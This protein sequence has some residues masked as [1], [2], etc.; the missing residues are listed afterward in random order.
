MPLSFEELAGLS[1]VVRHEVLTGELIRRLRS[2]PEVKEEDVEA[3]VNQL[4]TQTLETVCNGLQNSGV[5]LEQIRTA[6]E[7]LGLATPPAEVETSEEYNPTVLA[8]M[9]SSTLLDPSTLA[10]TAS[11]PEHP[12]TPVS[13]TPSMNSPPRTASPTGSVAPG[14]EK[15]RLL[16]AVV[17]LDPSKYRGEGGGGNQRASEVT[18]MLLSLSK[19]ERAMCLFSQEYLRAKVESARSI[20]D[21]L[22]EEEETA[23]SAQGVGSITSDMGKLAVN[24]ATPTTPQ[25]HHRAPGSVPNTPQTP[26]LSI[27]TSAAA[28]PAV[29][30]T[31]ATPYSASAPVHTLASLAKLPAVEIVKLASGQ[32]STG[33]PV[34]KADP[35]VLKSTDEFVDGLAEKPLAAQKQLL[36]EKL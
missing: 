27:G 25:P 16:G 36:G 29:P 26:D 13:F 21:A 31:P 14:T 2:F 10:A 35:A 7:V 6:K 12:S 19:K 28:S 20:L 33:L 9:S 18:E 34:P 24:A 22:T 8:A 1:P 4:I 23:P 15:E 3:V 5:L 30:V 17:Q 32:Q 11:A